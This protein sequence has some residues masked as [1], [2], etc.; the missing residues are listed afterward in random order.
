M[1]GK[2][3]RALAFVTALAVG[4]ASFT[5]PAK[6]VQAAVAAWSKGS[7]GKYYNDKGKVITGALKKG[8]D[9]SSW[10][11]KIN[12]D[13]VKAAGIEF[14]FVR[15][16]HGTDP[17]DS[18]YKYNL[19]EAKRVGIPVGVYFYSTTTST[20]QSVKDA[21][22]VINAIRGYKISYPVV[23]DMESSTQ[24]GLTD[25]Q[26][27]NIALAFM[28]EVKKAGYYPMFYCNEDWY[29]NYLNTGLLAGY[30]RWVARYASTYDTSIKRQ[31]W[32]CTSSGRVDGVPPEN[33][34]DL[35]FAFVDYTKIIT[36]RTM[37]AASY[38][39]AGAKWVK[40]S[41]GYR[42]Q[43][44]DGSYLKNSWKVID[45]KR[46]FFNSSGYRATGWLQRGSSWYYMGSDGVMRTGWVTV[47]G[48]KYY[49][50]SNGVMV[51]GWKKGSKNW[52]YFNSSGA[53]VTGWLNY[54]GKK[55]FL[56]SNGVMAIGWVKGPKNWYYFD[57]NGA[58]VT[59]W[60]NYKG[61]KYYL[62]KN[63][64]M[65]VGW[66]KGPKNW[67]YFNSSGAMVTGWLTY[68]G[69]KYFLQ[70][71]GVMKTGWLKSGSYWYY[72]ESSGTM[73]RSKWVKV[74]GKWYYLQS[75]GVMKTGWLSDKGKRYYLTQ[76]GSMRIGWLKYNGKYYYFNSSGAMVKSTT[77]KIGGKNYKF[78]ANGV[79][80]G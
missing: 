78:D 74:S 19:S 22:T 13:K 77:L 31:V 14:A 36:P 35:D 23:V 24:L 50:E 65:A 27:S 15:V 71:N 20:T 37:P 64:I 79:Y 62:H 44:S 3:K 68:K 46:Y 41:K 2:L 4:L 45:G 11:G 8:I 43:L 10:Q 54:N 53:M 56:K 30:D 16:G 29:R 38:Q 76:D 61:K 52:Y 75:N 60:L 49:M 72:L 67:Y 18:Y 26:R 28:K 73:A 21:R 63:G 70:S 80:V 40:D 66:V 69:N 39:E 47:N 59:G 9:V 58:M 6:P 42:Y 32:Q 7:D 5:M 33:T 51:T 57:S 1:R 48:K 25:T 55:Y 17:L 34:V 12:W